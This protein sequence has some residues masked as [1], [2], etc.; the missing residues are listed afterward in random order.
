MIRI[1]FAVP[2]TKEPTLLEMSGDVP[3]YKEMDHHGQ[4]HL[5]TAKRIAY[6]VPFG[7]T[8]NIPKT[9]NKKQHV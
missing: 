5:G 8:S 9:K 4:I 2:G 6:W 3:N 1:L 7:T